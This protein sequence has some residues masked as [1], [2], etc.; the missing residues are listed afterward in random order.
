MRRQSEKVTVTTP[1]LLVK[2][3]LKVYGKDARVDVKGSVNRPC[4][5]NRYTLDETG[6]VE[7]LVSNHY[8]YGKQNEL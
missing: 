5:R 2:V 8:D 6:P 7:L 4:E 3:T 1:A